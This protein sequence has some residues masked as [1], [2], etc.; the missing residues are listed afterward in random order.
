MTADVV[1]FSQLVQVPSEQVL[2][3]VSPLDVLLTSRKFDPDDP[4]R[5]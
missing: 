1:I 2:I 5:R 4:I 3:H